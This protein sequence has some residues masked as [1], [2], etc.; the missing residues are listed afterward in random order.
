MTTNRYLENRGWIDPMTLRI[1][2]HGYREC[3]YCNQSIIP[4]KRTFCSKQCVHEYRLRSSGSYLRQCV[5]ARDLGIC[6]GCGVD[7]K[8]IARQLMDAMDNLDKLNELR[9]QYNIHNKRNITSL[10]KNGGGLWDADHI[11]DV[12]NGGG[13]CGLENIRT[14]CIKCHK[15]KTFEKK[16]I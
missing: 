7:T 8:F 13:S 4:P 12:Q 5:Y 14:L 2:E 6:A 9:T 1:N 15:K 3:R 11:I 10:K 16:N